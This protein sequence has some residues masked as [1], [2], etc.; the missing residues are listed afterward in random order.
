MTASMIA[1]G[2]EAPRLWDQGLRLE[3]WAAAFG[4]RSCGLSSVLRLGFVRL[5]RLRGLGSVCS[6]QSCLA[7]P[8]GGLRDVLLLDEDRT[9]LSP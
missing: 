9:T 3:L 6:W 7:S 5:L 8:A 4:G 2:D 1:L